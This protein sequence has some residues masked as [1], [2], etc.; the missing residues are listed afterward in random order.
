MPREMAWSILKVPIPL[1]LSLQSPSGRVLCVR[2]HG[3]PAIFCPRG[4]AMNW[5]EICEALGS[6]GVIKVSLSFYRFLDS[7]ELDVETKALGKGGRGSAFR[8]SW[9]TP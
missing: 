6:M 1:A 9:R 2:G 3:W 7:L 5:S 8:R 4:E